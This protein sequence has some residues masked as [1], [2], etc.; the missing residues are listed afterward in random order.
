M[1]MNHRET[2][3]INSTLQFLKMTHVWRKQMQIL[4]KTS[5]SFKLPFSATLL[6]LFS[7]E[8]ASFFQ[9]IIYQLPSFTVLDT[10]L[11]TCWVIGL[12]H[13]LKWRTS[14]VSKYLNMAM[15]HSEIFFFSGFVVSLHSLLEAP[16]QRLPKDQSLSLV[17][18]TASWSR[19][20]PFS[21]YW[22][23]GLSQ[24]LASFSGKSVSLISTQEPQGISA[25]LN[26]CVRKAGKS[27]LLNK[28]FNKRVQGLFYSCA[29][30]L[31][32]GLADELLSHNLT[33]MTPTMNFIPWNDEFLL[34]KRVKTLLCRWISYC[35]AASLK[36]ISMLTL[37][38]PNFKRAKINLS[39]G[40]TLC[41]EQEDCFSR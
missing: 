14:Q 29:S 40:A 6:A 38:S 26:S 19:A 4:F 27:L 39:S 1:E 21:F 18:D 2:L 31:L 34:V 17:G 35:F 3:R 36:L 28:M 13:W 15:L 11:C 16:A 23:T 9:H 37:P 10:S 20:L 5:T 32:Y 8:V 25:K 30:V 12:F 33:G 41:Q 22:L 24:T 7:A